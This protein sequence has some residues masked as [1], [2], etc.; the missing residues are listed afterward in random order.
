MDSVANQNLT[1]A[2]RAA[3]RAVRGVVFDFGG[4]LVDESSWQRWVWQGLRRTG[5]VESYDGFSRRLTR[6]CL[7]GV[8]TGR[9]AFD[10]AFASFL[11]QHGLRW[12]PIDELLTV[13]NVSPGGDPS[14]RKAA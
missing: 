14:T 11:R 13:F 3:L 1:A 9:R 10:E 4:V 5:L 12:G 7:L 2:D 8:W 6:D